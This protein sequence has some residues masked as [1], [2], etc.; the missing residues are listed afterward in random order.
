MAYQIYIFYLFAIYI[1]LHVN[2]IFTNYSSMHDLGFNEIKWAP[3]VWWNPHRWPVGPNRR[4]LLQW[5]SVLPL[6][7]TYNPRPVEV[8]ISKS[9]YRYDGIYLVLAFRK[10]FI[11]HHPMILIPSFPCFVIFIRFSPHHSIFVLRRWLLYS[12]AAYAIPVS[13][14]SISNT[15]IASKIMLSTR[16]CRE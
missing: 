11:V 15:L 2:I 9:I 13:V 14:G 1:M 7:G 10:P 12:H 4:P 6:K 8:M 3:R 5:V 16:T